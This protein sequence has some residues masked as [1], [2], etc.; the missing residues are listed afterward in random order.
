MFPIYD[1]LGGQAA[2]ADI[3]ARPIGEVP[4]GFVLRQLRRAGRI[5]LLR[6]VALLGEEGRQ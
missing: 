6:A 4:A 5:P 2:A 3:I 1:K